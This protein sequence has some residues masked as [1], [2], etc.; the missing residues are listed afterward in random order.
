MPAA[1]QAT[2]AQMKL[3]VEVQTKVTLE[4]FDELPTIPENSVQLADSDAEARFFDDFD[5]EVERMII[6]RRVQLLKELVARI[7][8]DDVIAM[9]WLEAK[10]KPKPE[11]EQ[12]QP[13]MVFDW[14]A[15][16]WVEAEPE[17][18]PEPAPE[19]PKPKP[20]AK[21]PAAGKSQF[22]NFWKFP[23]QPDGTEPRCKWRLPENQQKPNYNPNRFNTGIPTGA[24]NNIV[25]LDLDVKDEGVREFRKYRREFGTPQTLTV[26]TPSGGKRYY[27]NQSH[28]DPDTER[29]IK[30]YLKNAPNPGEKGST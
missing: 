15:P 13:E 12:Q 6:K 10:T 2:K 22:A 11:P 5:V 26:D 28:A 7:E 18:T 1:K 21:P 30:A 25:V 9:K 4:L 27:F 29:M 24:R 16:G 17:P 3:Q 14:G 20:K 23:C 19:P 8:A